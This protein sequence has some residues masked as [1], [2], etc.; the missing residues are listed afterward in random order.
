MYAHVLA[1]LTNEASLIAHLTDVP[2][3]RNDYLG[4]SEGRV[5]E[6]LILSN[7]R[8]GAFLRSFDDHRIERAVSRDWPDRMPTGVPPLEANLLCQFQRWKL[9][10]HEQALQRVLGL[11]MR[12]SRIV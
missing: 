9:R 3:F 7:A 8:S 6:L 12:K 1:N 4:V 11:S 10:K 2:V 5:D